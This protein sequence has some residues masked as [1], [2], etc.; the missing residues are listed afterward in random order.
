WSF[1]TV[2]TYWNN[3]HHLLQATKSVNGWVMWGNLHLLFWLSL[4]PFATEWLGG[5]IGESWPTAVYCGVLLLAAIAYTLLER[6]IVGHEGRDS[7]LA[8][9]LGDDRKGK[10]S[11][12]CYVLSIIGAFVYPWISYLLV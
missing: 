9:A 4:I 11:L 6:A 3:H 2:G 1:Q 7:A 8:A 5:H 10:I 12:A